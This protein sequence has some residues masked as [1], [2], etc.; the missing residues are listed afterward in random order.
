ML[1]AEVFHADI[2]RNESAHGTLGHIK[3]PGHLAHGT[4]GVADNPAANRGFQLRRAGEPGEAGTE[5]VSGTLGLL[6]PGPHPIHTIP[7]AAKRATYLCYRD[8]R[9]LHADDGP[10]NFLC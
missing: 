10:A 4:L 6:V 7:R 2:L 5:S 1:L 8:I 9:H 3:V